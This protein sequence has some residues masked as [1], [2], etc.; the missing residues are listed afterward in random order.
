MIEKLLN[1]MEP[2]TRLHTGLP[3]GTMSSGAPIELPVTLIKGTAPG[4]CLW[5]NGQVHGGEVNGVVAA[6]EF[7]RRLDPATLTGSIVITPTG[8][9]L[10]FD[11]HSKGAPQDGLDLDQT[12]PG[13]TSGTVTGHL[14]H[15]LFSEVRGVA[16][17]VVNLHTML[18]IHASEP[19]C[20]YKVWPGGRVTEAQLLRMTSYF[21]PSVTCR[22][23]VGGGTGELPGN[24]AGALD[25]QCLALDIP[26]FMVELGQGSWYTPQN[27]ELAV[28]GLGE[29]ARQLGILPGQP[30]APAS[31]RRVTRRQ[32]LMVRHGGLFLSTR[33]PRDIIPAGEPIGQVVSLRGEVV[34]TVTLPVDAI[35]IGLRRDPVVHTGDRIG[36]F[37]T[38]WDQVAV[39]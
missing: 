12:Y 34:E 39:A 1:S 11:N 27:V 20:V 36:F 7:G 29:L 24:I 31:V 23:N 5:V 19:Y 2:G 16:S 21:N 26:A 25:Y 15:A 30:S 33:A 28:H 13:G 18:N 10:A 6:V 32:W 37:A 14:A 35:V 8:N 17:C 22:M 38:E 9:P 3:V 4:A